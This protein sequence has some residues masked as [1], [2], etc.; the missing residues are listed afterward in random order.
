MFS[1]LNLFKI[2]KNSIAVINDGLTLPEFDNVV[3]PWYKVF[4]TVCAKAS[5]EDQNRELIPFM[6]D[7]LNN[8]SPVDQ[9]K[10][11]IQILFSICENI[12]EEGLNKEKA[13]VKMMKSV[14]NETNFRIRIEGIMFLQRYFKMN[15]D[16]I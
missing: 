12:G 10:V 2:I 4:G 13:Y 6:Q 11:G 16:N 15:E 7:Q 14:F 9:R 3:E 8:K 1:D 5:F